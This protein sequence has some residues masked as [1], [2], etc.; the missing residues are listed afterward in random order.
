MEEMKVSCFLT[1]EGG[2]GLSVD[3]LEF[4]VFTSILHTS[5]SNLKG[6]GKIGVFGKV[7]LLK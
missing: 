5:L 1:V 2:K 7:M 6:C 4:C 3:S